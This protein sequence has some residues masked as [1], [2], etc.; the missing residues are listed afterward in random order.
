V[1]KALIVYDD[2]MNLLKQTQGMTEFLS[3]DTLFDR[4][5]EIARKAENIK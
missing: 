2:I 1:D 4:M 5:V 3:I